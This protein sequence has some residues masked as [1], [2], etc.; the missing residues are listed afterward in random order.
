MSTNDSVEIAKAKKM[1]ELFI[2]AKGWPH[3]LEELRQ[4]NDQL[5]EDKAR[6]DWLDNHLT[7]YLI[8]EL[9]GMD[10]DPAQRLREVIDARRTP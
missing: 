7:E 3:A 4:Q 1:A 10:V 2:D 5:R 9:F 8:V 6:L